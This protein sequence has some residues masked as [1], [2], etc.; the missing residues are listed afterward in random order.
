M[1]I[2]HVIPS[3]A[4]RFGG[5][6]MVVVEMC[7]ELARCGQ[8]VAIYTTDLG[9]DQDSPP[10]CTSPFKP[11]GRLDIRYFPIVIPGLF[12]VSSEL[13]RALR[14]TIGSYDLVHIHSLYRF[15]STAAAYYARRAGVPYIVRPHGTLDP[16]IF[17]R[18]RALKSIYEALFEKRNL[19]Q[20]AAVHFT[21][22][23]EL[24]LAKSCGIK[25]RGVVI[26][27]GAHR[28]I[29]SRRGW[30]EEFNR[31][32]P[33]TQGQQ[34]ILYF[35]RLNFKKGLDILA[36]AFGIVAR[37][38]DNVQFLIAGPDDEGYGV[39]VREWLAAEG[40]LERTTF[41]GML[42]GDAKQTALHGADMFVLASYSENFGLAVVEAMAAGLPVV[43]SD[44]VNIWREVAQAGAGLVT[45][46]DAQ[47]VARALLRMLDGQA[48]RETASSAGRRLVEQLFSWRAAGQRMIELYRNILDSQNGGARGTQALEPACLQDGRG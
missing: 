23:E 8:D 4:P 42:S 13:A 24:E 17:R 14:D 41:A 2:L 25:C 38:R 18:R 29:A 26:P 31:L 10:L 15:S 9:M 37:A 43:I 47:E 46:C 12:G 6:P 40:V 21:T 7:R 5:P 48:L 39:R 19:E 16:F 34:T 44:R 22:A 33:Q 27:L 1:R 32:W 45:R 30:R 28:D 3:L 20:A 35:G 11:P 36:R